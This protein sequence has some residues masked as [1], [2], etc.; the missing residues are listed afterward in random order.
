MFSKCMLVG[1]LSLGFRVWFPLSG[2]QSEIDGRECAGVSGCFAVMVQHG[3]SKPYRPCRG[4][5]QGQGARAWTAR[6][7]SVNSV[8]VKQVNGYHKQQDESATAG[9][10]LSYST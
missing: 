8:C 3:G 1:D 4:W 2:T 9:W 5:G 10:R 7:T 6:P